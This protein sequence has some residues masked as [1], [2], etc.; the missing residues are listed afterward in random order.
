MKPLFTEEEYNNASDKDLLPLECL[1][2]SK[3]F[4]KSKVTIRNAL[5]PNRKESCNHCSAKCT[6]ISKI[7]KVKVS[8]ELCGKTIERHPSQLK[9]HPISFCNKSCATK[10]HNMHKTTG[11]NRSKLE[12]WLEEQ[13]SITYPSM[14]ILYNNVNTIKAELD[15]YIPE[16]KLAFEIN[17]IFHYEP[18]FGDEKLNKTIS[19][20]SKKFQL[21]IKNKISL[22]VIDSSELKYF[23]PDR[24]QKYLDIIKKI[25]E[26]KI[27]KN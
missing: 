10:Y 9:L 5:N 13:L 22:C 7:K 15:I 3:I 23:K 20:D 12:F 26:A 14:I 1:I 16:L 11:C 6:G 8:C 27:S 24:A 18:I 17:G 4:Y 25:I 21:C 19:N 2:C